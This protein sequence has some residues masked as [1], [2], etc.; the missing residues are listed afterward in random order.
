MTHAERAFRM[1]KIVDAMVEQNSHAYAAGYLEMTVVELLGMLPEE[2]AE[3][4]LKHL[5][6]CVGVK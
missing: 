2:K 5:E 4:E 6:E 1:K 3:S